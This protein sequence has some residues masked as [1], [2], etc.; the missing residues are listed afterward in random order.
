MADQRKSYGLNPINTGPFGG[1]SEPGGRADSVPLHNFP[2]SYAFAY[3][4]CKNRVTKKGTNYLEYRPRI[5][6][7][8][9]S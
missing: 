2:I 9:N 5:Y 6:I 7:S 1:S 8:R 4:R 3:E